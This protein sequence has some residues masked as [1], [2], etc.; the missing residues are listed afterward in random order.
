[1]GNERTTLDAFVGPFRFFDC[2][3]TEENGGSEQT[4]KT[5]T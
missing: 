1:M 3:F 5:K 4:W 2:Q